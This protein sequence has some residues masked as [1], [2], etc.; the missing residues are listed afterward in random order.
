MFDI[1]NVSAPQ[2]EDECA[3]SNIIFHLVQSLIQY[4]LTENVEPEERIEYQEK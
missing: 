2:R 1:H 4:T 3:M